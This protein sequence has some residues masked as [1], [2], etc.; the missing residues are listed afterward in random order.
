IKNIEDLPY[1]F[2]DR[3]QFD[4]KIDPRRLKFGSKIDDKH[5]EREKYFRV[6]KVISP[7]ELVLSNNLT[8]RLLGVK[9]IPEQFKNAV[10]YLQKKTGESKV[11]IKFDKEKYDSEN[12]LLC[13]LYLSNNTFLN[14]H[15][16]K[17]NLATV[18]DSLDFKFKN[19]F[20]LMTKTEK[21]DGQRVDFESGNE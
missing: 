19:R 12:K 1:I 6:Q 4:K 9:I 8:I 3:I 10:A 5:T 17:N 15:L 21:C 13:Y 14:A 2:K 11:F 16:I 18:D 7:I 20:T